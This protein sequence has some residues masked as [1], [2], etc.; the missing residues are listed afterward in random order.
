MIELLVV[1]A[2]IAALLAMTVTYIG[3]SQKKAAEEKTRAGLAAIEAGIKR[4]YD[5]FGEY[6]RPEDNSGSGLGGAIALYQALLDDGGNALVN[7]S[8]SSDGQA[9]ENKMVDLVSEGLVASDGKDFYLQDGYDRPFFYMVYDKE[10]PEATH[11]QTFDLWSV[12]EDETKADDA[13]WITN[14]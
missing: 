13:K 3:Y 9:G 14:W 7:G 11:Q 5:R 1:I 10:D 8:G 4:Y 12:G 2:I 6:P